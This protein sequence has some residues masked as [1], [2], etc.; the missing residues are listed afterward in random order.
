MSCPKCWS[1][2]SR[3]PSRLLLAALAGLLLGPA[4]QMAAQPAQGASTM[5]AVQPEPVHV[6]APVDTTRQAKAM[7]PEQAMELANRAELQAPAGPPSR[8]QVTL[9]TPTPPVAAKEKSNTWKWV[10]GTCIGL[11]LG[12]LLARL[13]GAKPQ[14]APVAMEDR[15]ATARR[16]R[17]QRG[18]GDN[19]A[20]REEKKMSKSL[21]QEFLQGPM[22]PV[23]E[24]KP[25]S[26]SPPA[27][28]ASAPASPAKTPPPKSAKA[29]RS[30]SNS[31]APDTASASTNPAPQPATIDELIDA[32]T[33]TA[34]TP[35]ADTPAPV[36]PAGPVQFYAP[37]PDV[38]SIEHRKLS[39]NPLPQM[40]IFIQLSHPEA[41]R[42]EFSFSSQADQ[43]R[44]IGNGVRELKEFFAFDLPPTEQ[45][46]TIK[47]L[48]PGKLEK[49]DD[50]WHVVQKATIALS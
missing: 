36:A 8:T 1:K 48:S 35:A 34:A 38:P 13:L 39:P 2:R 4:A 11:I 29:S 9:D 49:R 23:L 7:S 24:K 44:I 45:F 47:N 12:F 50:T 21:N 18:Q 30:M 25:P 27:A 32:G 26:A 17:H 5:P 31:S 33:T 28:S 16:G 22:R 37:A 43:S 41:T 15:D 19:P 42:A 10:L 3:W 46:T 6:T 20:S 40:P 14:A